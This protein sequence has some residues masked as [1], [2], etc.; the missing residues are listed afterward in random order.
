MRWSQAFFP[1]LRDDPAEAE[2][3]SHKLLV[4]GGFIRQLS[5]GH[6]SMLPLGQRVRAKIDRIIRE[7]MDGIGG[8]QFH[9]PAIHP[10][11]LWKKSGRWDL[12]GDELF[13]LKDRKG[14]DLALGFTHEEVFATLATEISSYRDLPQ[15]WYQIQTKYRDEPRPKSGLLRVREFTMKD[16]YSLDVDRQGL[17]MAFDK[18]HAAYRR[19]LPASGWR[20]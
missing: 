10:A 15:I 9:L 16:S 11:E 7:E 1:T 18:H 13:R 8:Q 2:A 4:R 20:R 6:Y 14:A 5:A 17:D 12:M 3:V 19:I